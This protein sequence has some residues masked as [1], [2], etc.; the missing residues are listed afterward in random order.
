M[1]SPFIKPIHKKFLTKV[2][3]LSADL[4]KVSFSHF[5][6]DEAFPWIWHLLSLFPTFLTS[7]PGLFPEN[8]FLGTLK[9][10]KHVVGSTIQNTISPAA[11]IKNIDF[12]KDA[13][14]CD[15][16][17]P[18]LWEN[19]FSDHL[20]DCTGSTLATKLQATLEWGWVSWYQSYSSMSRQSYCVE[21]RRNQ[22]LLFQRWKRLTRIYLIP[23]C[24]G[25]FS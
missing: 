25:A 7:L 18:R 23:S 16:A 5:L 17:T 6:I 21:T 15:R 8:D 12:A 1:E 11:F 20:P 4:K 24:V 2:F 10:G 9:G 13:W 22:D 19:Q 3:W 14:L